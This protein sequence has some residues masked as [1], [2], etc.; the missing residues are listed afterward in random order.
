MSVVFS[1][2][3]ATISSADA[4]INTKTKT[5]SKI[6]VYPFQMSVIF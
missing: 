2:S 4:F 1:E 3:P 6:Q 5:G